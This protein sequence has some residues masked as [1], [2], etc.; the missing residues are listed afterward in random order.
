MKLLQSLTQIIIESKVDDIYAKYYRNI[1]RTI[2]DNIV[3]ADPKSKAENGNVVFMGKYAKILLNIY[4]IGNMPNLENLVEATR[5]LDIIYNKNLAVDLN[6]IKQ[7]SD[8][9]PIVKDY[10][11]TGDT[12]IRTILSELPKETYQLLHNGEKWLVFRPKTEKAA[13]WLGVGSAWCTSWGKYT[14]TPA[15]KGRVNR[16][17]QYNYA[18]IYIMIDKSDEKHKFQF[19]FSKKEYRDVVDGMINIQ[20]FFQTHKELR[21]FFFPLLISRNESS[22]FSDEEQYKRIDVLPD[23]FA[24]IIQRYNI[25]DLLEMGIENKVALSLASNKELEELMDDG[26]ISDTKIESISYEGS[27]I[28]FEM[29][30]ECSN[31]GYYIKQAYDY[32]TYLETNSS[33]PNLYETMRDGIMDEDSGILDRLIDSYFEKNKSYVSFIKFNIPTLEAFVSMFKEVIIKNEKYKDK[34]LESYLEKAVDLTQPLYIGKIE[35]IL[36]DIREYFNISQEYYA[37]GMTLSA[38]AIEFIKYIDNKNKPQISNFCDVFSDYI[39]NSGVDYDE[40]YM[41]YSEEYPDD[42]E[43]FTVI[44]E[45]IDDFIANNFDEF[46]ESKSELVAARHK[47]TDLLSKHFTENNQPN[48]NEY[49]FKFKNSIVEIYANNIIDEKDLTTRVDLIDLATKEKYFGSIKV[50]NLHTYM[51]NYK[52]ELITNDDLIKTK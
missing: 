45:V 33:N 14:L 18:P 16:F 34:I 9:H 5:Y 17:S 30:S 7:I 11:V 4:K 27:N 6:K 21:D 52:L 40:Y 37:K 50:D 47:L 23:T 22:I 10:L 51:F 2:F 24:S 38:N 39:D 8:L 35:S 15:Y 26:S 13:S 49:P 36:N 48:R 25:E 28:I 12:P 42:K 41:D 31:S 19:Q 29:N 20:N 1:P 46:D 44:Q 3:M 32:I 43:M